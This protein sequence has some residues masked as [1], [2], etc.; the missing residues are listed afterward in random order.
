[1]K[2]VSFSIT[3]HVLVQKN[4]KLTILLCGILS[5][6]DT[7]ARMLS[8]LRIQSDGKPVEVISLLDNQI[9]KVGKKRND[10]LALA[11]GEYVC[12][13]D[14]DDLISDDYVD[15]ILEAIET[16]ED[17]VVFTLSRSHNGI[18]DRLCYYSKD[19]EK[20]LDTPEAYYRTPNHLMVFRT[21]IAQKVKYR[22][23]FYGEDGVWAK[24]VQ[25]YLKSERKIDKVL[26]TYLSSDTG[27]ATH[28]HYKVSIIIH[29]DWSSKAPV[30]FIEY[31]QD[32]A[33]IGEILIFSQKP[34]PYDLGYEK[35][36]HFV[37]D[38]LEWNYSID[39][40]Q[41]TKICALDKNVILDRYAFHMASGSLE[42]DSVKMIGLDESCNER[43]E[44]SLQRVDNLNPLFSKAMFFKKQ[45]FPGIDCDTL[46]HK[47][48]ETYANESYTIKGPK[49][50]IY[51]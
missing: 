17:V 21:E 43:T 28:H 46:E 14:D 48:F 10:L 45:F 35:V 3:L 51:E 18:H 49:V 25:P 13:V 15:S 1:M 2:F 22:E 30:I 19:Y 33:C 11:N 36:K 23:W 16:G 26:Y 42:D 24:E 38:K 40:A 41:F 44:N 50:F 27:S 39:Q 9:M 34:S 31:A 29:T 6:V 12:F 47:M 8:V 20:D 32:L 4:L 5:R 37:V 7:Y